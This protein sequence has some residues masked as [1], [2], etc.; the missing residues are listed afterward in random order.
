MRIADLKIRTRLAIGFGTLL[1]LLLTMLIITLVRFVAIERANEMLITSAWAKADAAHTIN[2][3]VRSNGR[4]LLEAVAATDA[5]QRSTLNRYIDDNQAEIGRAQGVLDKY[6]SSEQGKQLLAAVRRHNESFLKA[7]STVF[8][9]LSADQRDAALS[10]VEKDALPALDAMQSESIELVT[11]QQKI[12]DATGAST[13]ADIA[14][15]KWLLAAIGGV[16]A[17]VGIG[18]AWSVTRSIT[19]PLAR[20]VQVAERVA[21]GDLTSRIEVTSR[22]ET[23]QLMAALKHMNESLDQIVRRVRS[24]TAAIASAS[25]Q[26]LAGNTDL[27]ART[28][29]QAASLE[30]TASSMEE[31]T[32]TVRQN[33][34]N[35]RQA[36]QLAVNAS[37]IAGDGGRVVERAVSSMQ[38]IAASSAKINDIIGVIDGIAF[39]TNILALNAAVEAARAGEQ[40]RGFAVVAGEVRTLAQRSAAAAKEIK[41]LIETSVSKVDD[42]SSQVRDAGRTMTDIVQ[43]VQRVTDIMGE[44]SAASAEQT[45]GIEQVNTAVMQMDQV[46]QQNAALVEEATAAAGSLEDQ[47][48]H[49]REAVAVFR[50]AGNDDA[51]SS[52]GGDAQTAANGQRGAV[53]NFARQR[54]A[55]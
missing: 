39:Q 14:F 34:E 32:A 55:A 51:L 18:A 10:V 53:L 45:G 7:R 48:R 54:N 3:M 37:E 21:Q 35:A 25:G 9:Q 42:G 28:E 47:A 52:N 26:L 44:I 11:L 2:A 15:A 27:S 49:L 29:E 1:I 12:V 16:A 41:A 50:L 46:T 4:R 30:E 31:L 43:A 22:D 23:G 24:G 40:G 33:A 19:R 36:S 38:E 8:S 20:A 17:V 5:A 6:V 13:S